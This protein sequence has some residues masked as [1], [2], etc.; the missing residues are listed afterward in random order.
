MTSFVMEAKENYDT[1]AAAKLFGNTQGPTFALD[2]TN[3]A[4]GYDFANRNMMYLGF[5]TNDVAVVAGNPIFTNTTGHTLYNGATRIIAPLGTVNLGTTNVFLPQVCTK[6]LDTEVVTFHQTYDAAKT[7]PA[8]VGCLYLNVSAKGSGYTNAAVTVSGGGGTGMVVTP[9]L[10][11]GGGGYLVNVAITDWGT[12][13]TGSP[14]FT[15]TGDGAGATIGHSTFATPSDGAWRWI[16]NEF[17]SSPYN[18]FNSPNLVNPL[19]GDFF[20]V[21]SSC[22]LFQLR[23]SDDFAQIMSPAKIAKAANPHLNPIPML[24]GIDAT[25]CYAL[26]R[27]QPGG[28]SNLTDLVL[29]PAAVQSDEIAAASKLTYVLWDTAPFST[30]FGGRLTFGTDGNVYVLSIGLT[31]GEQVPLAAHQVPSRRS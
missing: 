9:I 30:D 2:P 25:W 27:P 3:I 29:V 13:Y 16:G 10:D 1:A 15:V 23:A 31:G 6:N 26:T 18:N 5:T 21:S 14:T 24:V 11:A 28:I 12:G 4:C 8:D 19:N 7:V 22:D 20:T 17:A